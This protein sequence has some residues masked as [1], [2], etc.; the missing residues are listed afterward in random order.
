MFFHEHPAGQS[1]DCTLWRRS[2]V[3]VLTL[4]H[5]RLKFGTTFHQKVLSGQ[6]RGLF[7]EVQRTSVLLSHFVNSW[8]FRGQATYS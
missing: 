2:R 1:D 3:M 4:D 7:Q 6:V 8:D 5:R